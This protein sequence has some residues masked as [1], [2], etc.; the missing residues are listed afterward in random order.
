L[1]MTGRDAP[2]DLIEFADYVTE[3]HQIKHAYYQ[4][5]R[6]RKGIEY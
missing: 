4:G 3:L 1:I 6:A 5:V 2:P